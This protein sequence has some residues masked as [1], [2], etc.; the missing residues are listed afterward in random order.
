MATTI[1]AQ[2]CA[3]LKERYERNR[4]SKE[5][6]FIVQYNDLWALANLRRLSR[7][8]CIWLG[9]RV[10]EM[11]EAWTEPDQRTMLDNLQARQARAWDRWRK[12]IEEREAAKSAGSGKRGRKQ[13]PTTTAPLAPPTFDVWGDS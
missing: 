3:Q 2:R 10:H 13:Q 12:R 6:R 8:N 4:D 11:V 7:M 1:Y 9:K 5:L